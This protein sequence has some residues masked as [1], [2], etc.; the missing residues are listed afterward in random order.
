MKDSSVSP[1]GLFHPGRQRQLLSGLTQRC[2]SSAD[3]KSS[4][5][6]RHEAEMQ[7]EEES[8][9]SDRSSVTSEC[10]QQ[11]RSM[12]T[13]WDDAEEKLIADYETNAIRHRMELNRLASL[14]RKKM[15]EGKTALQRKVDARRE[16]VLHQFEQRKDDP[17]KQR[18][19][20]IAKI[21]ESLKPLQE[22]LNLARELTVR[23]LD[24][25]PPVPPI[26]SPEEDMSEP[27]PA[28]VQQT[29]ETIF[30]LSRKGQQTLLDMQT[31][32]TAKI[33]DSFYLPAGVAIAVAIWVV[34][35]FVAQPAALWLWLVGGVGVIGLIGIIIYGILLLPLRKMTRRLHPRMER[36]AIAADEC[37]AVGRKISTDMANETS[38]ELLQRRDAHLAAALRWQEEQ[39]SE[40]VDRLTAEQEAARKELNARLMTLDSEFEIQ[41]GRIN[42][43]MNAKA[44]QV[45]ARITE[46]LSKSDQSLQQQ[47]EKNAQRRRAELAHVT[48]RLRQ[49]IQGGMG[50][51]EAAE[52]LIRSQYPDWEQILHGGDTSRAQ[53]N[54]VPV[55]HLKIDDLLT[56]SFDAQQWSDLSESGSS[57]ADQ[58]SVFNGTDFPTELPIALHRRLHSGLLI[59]ASKEQMPRA[60]DLLHQVLWRLL[61]GVQGSRAKLTLIDPIG[62]GQNFTSFMALADHDPSLV[63]HRVWAAENQIESRL[64]EIAQHVEDVLQSSLRDQFQRI[65]D[66]NEIAGSMAEPYRAVGAVGL[67]EG[68]TR[69]GYKHLKALIESG[70][71]CGVFVLM[72][73]DADQPWTSDMPCPDDERLL[74]LNL[75]ATGKWTL[76][77]EGLDD[78]P[79]TPAPPPPSEMR[80]SLAENVGRAAVEASRV[81]IPLQNILPDSQCASGNTDDGICITVG[82]QGGNRSIALDLGEGV[83]QH[84]LI[85]GK[86]GS[87]KS[88][89]LHSI[90]TSGAFHYRPDQLEFY[91]LDFKKGVEFKSYADAQLPHAR[92]IGIESEREFGRSVLQRLDQELQDR[93]ELF[94]GCSTQE[95]SDYRRVSGK[96]MPRIVLVVD[97]FQELFVRD[98]KVAA[99]CSMLLDRLVRQGRS[100]GI[101][102]ILSS[103]SLAGAYSL[104]RATLGQMAVRIAMQCSESDAALILSDENTAARLITR[105]GE[106]IYNDAGGLVEGNQPFQVAWLSNDVHQQMLRDIA[107][108]DQEFVDLLPPPVIFEGNRPGRWS[109]ALA[110]AAS[111]PS[112]LGDLSGLLGESVAIGPPVALKLSRNAGR[113]VLMIPSVEARPGLLG[114]TISGFVKSDRRLEV[115]YFDGN[116]ASETTP[117]TPW[118][119]TAGIQHT[120]V[121]ARESEKE[122]QRIAQIV[123]ERGDDAPD[124]PPILI[125]V[126]PMDRFRDLRQEETFNFSLDASDG[127][128]DGAQSMR[129]ILKDGP[130]ANVY[131]IL[132]CGSTEI[133]NRWLPRSSHHDLE[134]RVLGRLNASDSSMLIDSPAASDLSTATLLLYDESDGRLTKFRQCDL[135]D[136]DSVNRWLTET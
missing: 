58:E 9:M 102:V 32:A 117:L 109:T 84:V 3:Q 12:L 79:F 118:L 6:K 78:L 107:N 28:S 123:R 132:V 121:R 125:V 136:P 70:V 76:Q 7:R 55:G 134:L 93:G 135:P 47:R 72:V 75:D 63:S 10:R 88:T 68:L 48:Q 97:E 37:A 99:E 19:A 71:R 69:A 5:L 54:V 86:T 33:V 111:P 126:D 120:V 45:A 101:H 98:D 89:L 62:R 114:S 2:R 35:V 104:P 130:P 50:H 129:E 26:E 18:A 44:E 36:I 23:R 29:I 49:G 25:L 91:L 46:E 53:L 128:A 65:E 14:Y 73:V 30:Q 51:I 106:A 13:Q 81:E 24:R 90:I 92:V 8:L 94:R 57:N 122:M 100:F 108:R 61:T 119:E 124:A 95:L 43:E 80:S 67:P 127:G 60:V 113:N 52:K 83:R 85:A 34:S 21:N 112:P 64:G 11:R 22:E 27:A 59:R 87:G 1:V 74:Q 4:L 82:S 110:K 40:L 66:Y 116:R 38:A 39:W 31:D 77:C 115:V 15:A 16:A 56:R 17:G 133:L 42:T 41:Q 20:E 103:Q 105:P 96:S 131:C